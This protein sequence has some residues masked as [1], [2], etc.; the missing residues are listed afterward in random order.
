MTSPRWR[1]RSV[2]I[3]C[4]FQ[5]VS[6][7]NYV[8]LIGGSTTSSGVPSAM[9][10][11]FDVA[12]QS[13]MEQQSLST[14]R[15]HFVAV[16]DPDSE[17]I[18]V[19]GGIQDFAQNCVDDAELI[20]ATTG[21]LGICY[22]FSPTAD[23]TMEP[24]A[25]P[26]VEPTSEP[27]TALPTTGAPTMEPT[28]VPSSAAKEDDSSRTVAVIFIVLGIVVIFLLMLF[29]DYYFKKQ[30]RENKRAQEAQEE[31]VALAVAD[32]DEEKP[33]ATV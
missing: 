25:V 9:V 23:P 24:T 12:N 19:F 10:E 5:G 13:V 17:R 20:E 2:Q 32:Y 18:F 16:F 22:T 1:I 3:Q 33:E 26:T 30:E 11:V 8:A 21:P 14:A 31:A 6:D 29:G 28:A 27:T 15:D 4:Q 7:I